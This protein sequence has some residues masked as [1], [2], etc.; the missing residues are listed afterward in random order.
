MMRKLLLCLSL[1]LL[2]LPAVGSF[3][4]RRQRKES[5]FDTAKTQLE[6]NVCADREYK[7]A[8]ATLNRVYNQLAAKLGDE[9][10]AKLKEVE[11]S[12]LKYRDANCAFEADAYTGGSIQPL[13]YSNCMARMTKARTGEL[14]EQ[15]KETEN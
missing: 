15:L 6:L 9:A 12:W 4:Q 10:K 7:A 14:S 11:L 13:I 2:A 3:A 8:D 1:S 5:C